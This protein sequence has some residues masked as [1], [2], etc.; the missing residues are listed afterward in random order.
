MGEKS[1]WS[2]IAEFGIAVAKGAYSVGEGLVYGIE[3]SGEGLG[4][5]GTGR[6]LQIAKENELIAG[7]I[8]DAVRLAPTALNNPLNGLIFICARRQ[9]GIDDRED[10]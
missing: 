5:R 1:T 8:Y 7:L 2:I 3:R 9:V 4:V 6:Q 10:Q